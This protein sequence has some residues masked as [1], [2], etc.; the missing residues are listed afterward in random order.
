MKRFVLFL[1]FMMGLSF[2]NSIAVVEGWLGRKTP[3]VRTPKFNINKQSDS[4]QEN[5][6]LAKNINKSTWIELLLMLYFV[7]VLVIEI[8]LKKFG[9]VPFHLMLIVGYGSVL[10]YTFRQMK[11]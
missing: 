3:F 6:Y 7:F 9:L 2:H 8:Q 11:V 5:K 10:F 4:W 1:L